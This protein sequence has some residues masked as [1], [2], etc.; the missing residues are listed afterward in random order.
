LALWCPIDITI[1]QPTNPASESTSP[2]AISDPTSVD[3][4]LRPGIAVVFG[5]TLTPL[6]TSWTELR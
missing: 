3:N 5:V 2:K 4:V 1:A 6:A